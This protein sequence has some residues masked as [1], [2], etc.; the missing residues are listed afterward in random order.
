M[1]NIKPLIVGVLSALGLTAAIMPDEVKSEEIAPTPVLLTE[2]DDALDMPGTA[3]NDGTIIAGYTPGTDDLLYTTPNDAPGFY[4]WNQGM[5]YCEDLVAH[6]HDD[7]KLPTIDQLNLLFNNHS[8]VGNF[9]TSPSGKPY[10]ANWYWS[11][12]VLSNINRDSAIQRFSDGA[13]GSGSHNPK[14]KATIRC[15]RP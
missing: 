3:M 1:T 6:G 13:I 15:V 12:T 14:M 10:E 4:D 11:S 9:K 7:W 2:D 5:E 8:E